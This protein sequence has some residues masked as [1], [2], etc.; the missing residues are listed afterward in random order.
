MD[1]LAAPT[2]SLA[3]LARSYADDATRPVAVTEAALARIAA[4]EPVLHAFQVV[5]ADGALAM[6]RASTERWRAGRPLGPLDGG[7]GT[8]TAT[9]AP[10]PAPRDAPV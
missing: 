6:A 8:S 2:P 7:P 10:A 5:D 1:T 4:I 3:D 9:T